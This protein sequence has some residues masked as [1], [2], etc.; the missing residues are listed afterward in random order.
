M[1]LATNVRSEGTGAPGT[2]AASYQDQ[3]NARRLPGATPLWTEAG[4][5]QWMT[6]EQDLWVIGDHL[7]EVSH[8][9][10]LSPAMIRGLSRLDRR[11][12]RAGLT[13]TVS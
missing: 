13:G 11:S 7:G 1:T 6:A 2:V 3:T 8:S 12:F 5:I 9:P 10:L 4:G